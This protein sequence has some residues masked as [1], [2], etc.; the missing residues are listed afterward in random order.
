M[1]Y[2]LLPTLVAVFLF[3][4]LF[5]P[6]NGIWFIRIL[7]PYL[8]PIMRPLFTFVRTPTVDNFSRL[9]VMELWVSQ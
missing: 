4:A 7:G 5:L 9:L 3:A 8:D 6:F 1:F 2:D